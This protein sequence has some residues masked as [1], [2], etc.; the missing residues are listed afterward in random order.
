MRKGIMIARI[1]AAVMTLTMLPQ[2]AMTTLAATPTNGSYEVGAAILV[3]GESTDNAPLKV[4]AGDALTYTGRLDV[5]SIKDQFADVASGKEAL[6][7]LISLS[8]VGSTFTTSL[9]L[10]SELT[11][12]ESEICKVALT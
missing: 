1:M 3:N 5:K 2:S 12:D 4:K 11:V 9:T 7:S 8:D 6:M 10:P